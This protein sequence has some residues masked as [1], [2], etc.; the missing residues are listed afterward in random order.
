MTLLTDLTIRSDADS[1]KSLIEDSINIL[2]NEEQRFISY[3]DF[4]IRE[5]NDFDISE[6]CPADAT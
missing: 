1:G 5:Q 4:F 2:K 6:L 3:R